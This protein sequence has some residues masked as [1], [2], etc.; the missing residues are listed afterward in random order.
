[1][2]ASTQSQETVLPVGTWVDDT[3]HSSASFTVKYLVSSFTGNFPAIDAKLDVAEDGSAKLVGTV[4]TDSVESR[5]E[6]LTAHLKA[7]DFF[8]VEQYPEVKFESTDITR[9][10][11]EIVVAGDL[12]IKGNT[13][14]VEGRGTFAGPLEDAYGNSKVGLNLETVV[15]RT[16][17]GLDW[18]A[19]LPAGGFALA[20]EVKLVIE[21]HL[22]KA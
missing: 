22:I 6:G 10:G 11:E 3:A 15:D 9:N 19:E 18:N 17:F 5:A 16:K 14:R 7:P 20:N 13:N 8:D 4:K 2:T 21:L 1:M 12:T